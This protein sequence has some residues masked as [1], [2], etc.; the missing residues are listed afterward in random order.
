[1]PRLVSPGQRQEW[2]QRVQQQKE[3]GQSMI[4]WCHEHQVNYYAL[5]YWRKQF[6]VPS[7]KAVE[8]SSFQELPPAPDTTPITLEYQHIQLHLPNNLDPAILMKY[9]RALKGEL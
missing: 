1:M 2:E 7:T 5:L 3:S 6:G 8:R 9:L 4:R